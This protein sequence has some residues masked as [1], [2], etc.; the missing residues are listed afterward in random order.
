MNQLDWIYSFDYLGDEP[1]AVGAD[2]VKPP[3]VNKMDEFFEMDFGT[4]LKE[5]SQKTTKQFQG[6]SVYKINKKAGDFSKGDQFYLDNLHKDHIEVFDK[7]GNF[8]G[9]YN[10]D[11]KIN[12][13]KTQKAM[14]DGRKLKD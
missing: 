9:V 3:S 14:Q 11:G 12:V 13:D 8:K 10:F 4:N 6:Q 7:R 1:R 2:V 5:L